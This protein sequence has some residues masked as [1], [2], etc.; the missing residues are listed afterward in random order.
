MSAKRQASARRFTPVKIEAAPVIAGVIEI[1]VSSGC[2]RVRG[3]V[4]GATLHA[5][6]A[7][8]R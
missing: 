1:D 8:L 4:D 3:A 7:A 2:I 6:V 5:A